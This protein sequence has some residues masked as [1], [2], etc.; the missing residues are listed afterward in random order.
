M[1]PECAVNLVFMLQS[2]LNGLL[3]RALLIL[4]SAGS[5]FKNSS[6]RADYME[7]FS[8][9]R[10]WRITTSNRKKAGD[11]SWNTRKLTKPG[12]RTGKNTDRLIFINPVRSSFTTL[13]CLQ[14]I[15]ANNSPNLPVV[16]TLAVVSI[17]VQGQ[18]TKQTNVPNI[19]PGVV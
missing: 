11:L 3:L 4:E 6:A 10:K 16:K 17:V 12:N 15:S 19:G 9:V 18:L 7:I 13:C 1:Q 8:R 5:W 2:L 14:R